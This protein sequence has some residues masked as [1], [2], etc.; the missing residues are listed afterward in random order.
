MSVVNSKKKTAPT[1]NGYEWAGAMAR[2]RRG[3][4]S[5]RSGRRSLLLG[6]LTASYANSG[7]T[8]RRS[9]DSRTA[10]SADRS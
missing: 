1:H 3:G 9:V 7:R 6:A 4:V 5:A 10:A 8:G 2:I